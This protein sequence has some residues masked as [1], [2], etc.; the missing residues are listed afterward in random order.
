[1]AVYSFLSLRWTLGS[2]VEV[3]AVVAASSYQWQSHLHCSEVFKTQRE[4]PHWPS[5]ASS[6]YPWFLMVQP[7]IL[8]V[9]VLSLELLAQQPQL[10]FLCQMIQLQV[11]WCLWAFT[12]TAAASQEST[13]PTAWLALLVFC[14]I[15]IF[16]FQCAFF[17]LISLFSYSF[18]KLLSVRPRI[19]K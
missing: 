15:R 16:E 17:F 7:H 2:T 19:T 3:G 1:M 9:V 13:A 5:A 6:L 11:D 10:P 8:I 12:R 4:Y 18:T 14:L